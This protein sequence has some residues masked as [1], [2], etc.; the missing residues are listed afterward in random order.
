MR[1]WGQE[2]LDNLLK[3]TSCSGHTAGEFWDQ[4]RAST[5]WAAE[6]DFLSTVPKR[7]DLLFRDKDICVNINEILSE[8]LSNAKAGT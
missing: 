7:L 5:H 8:I 2:S 4:N 1:T 6:V 3:V